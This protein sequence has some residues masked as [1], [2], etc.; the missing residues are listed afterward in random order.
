MEC[1][2]E[3]TDDGRWRC[4]ACGYVT[5]T[6][7]ETPPSKNCGPRPPA[8]ALPRRFVTPPLATRAAELAQALTRFVAS[9]GKLT[10]AKQRKARRAACAVCDKN[11]GGFC[12]GCSACWIALKVRMSTESCPDDKWPVEL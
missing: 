8:S 10:P 2:F 9:G 3:R 7:S 1:G 5:K 12:Y 4:S 6:P 11:V